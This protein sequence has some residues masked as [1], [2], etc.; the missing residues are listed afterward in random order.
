[1]KNKIII[2]A[3][4]VVVGLGIWY[5]TSSD[6]STN[7]NTVQASPT[8]GTNIGEI[9]DFAI[10]FDEYSFSPSVIKATPGKKITVKLTNVGNTVHDFVIDKL[11]VNSAQLMSGESKTI[12]I[13]VPQQSNTY[14]M[15]CSVGNHRALGMVGTFTIEQL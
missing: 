4:I 11:G 10:E 3:V 7:T 2:I 15:Y 5:F 9:V 13:T 8:S 12:T 1:M 14:E 6:S